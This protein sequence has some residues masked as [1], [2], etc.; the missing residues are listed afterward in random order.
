MNSSLVSLALIHLLAI[1]SPGPNVALVMKNSLQG[2]RRQALLCALGISLGIVLHILFVILGVSKFLLA[3][4]PLL[5][6]IQV[7]SALYLFYLGFLMLLKK[8]ERSEAA[9]ENIESGTFLK[10]IG[11]SLINPK[12]LVYF[13]SVIGPFLLREKLNMLGTQVL[14]W[15]SVLTFI[16]F[17]SLAFFLTNPI[18]MN[19]YQ[20][21]IWLPEKITGL[22][23]IYLALHSLY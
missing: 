2:N 14:L 5:R 17:F 4:G 18:I 13:S 6:F 23:L 11:L 1:M 16:W 12:A 15:L 22:G 10:S 3:S 21:Y 19:R 8:S 7:A 9:A 20:S